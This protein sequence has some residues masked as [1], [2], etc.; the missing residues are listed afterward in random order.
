[1]VTIYDIARK[2]GL[3][4]ATVSKALND[5]HGVSVKSRELVALSAKEMG[6][7]P[8]TSARTLITKKSWLMGVLYSED[9]GSGFVHPHFNPILDSVNKTAEKLGYDVV[10]VNRRLG[11]HTMTYYEHC[12]YRGVDGIIII[13][14]TGS[15]SD[16]DSLVASPIRSV[17]VEVTYPNV[18]TV[19]SDN[20]MGTLQALEYLY[21]LGHHKIALIS[22][23]L[24]SQGGYERYSAYLEF[25]QQK[26]LAINE[27]HIS[28]SFA[29][30]GKAGGD[31]MRRLLEQSWGNLPTAIFAAYDEAAC[32]GQT[33]LQ[34]QGFRIPEDMSIVGFDNL[35]ITEFMRPRIT[36][37][38]QNR[39]EIGRK[40][41][42]ILSDY[43]ASGNVATG[44][45][46]RIPTRLVVRDSCRRI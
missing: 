23:P 3:S 39:E 29:Y 44:D 43:L 16:I 45:I 11:G 7:T 1:M 41:T 10:F 9:I 28:E 40:A 21:F 35:Q 33:I 25:M 5:Y 20:R 26:G 46:H 42:C 4:P 24:N 31:A 17:S 22:A 12:L 6:Y 13:A 34:S 19:T 38:E 30:N 36:T 8:N 32:V 15:N 27:N 18:P 2:T 37:V 14:G